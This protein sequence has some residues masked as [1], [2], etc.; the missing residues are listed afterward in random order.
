MW[1]LF[2]LTQYC[3]RTV[4]FQLCLA[5]FLAAFRR[6]SFFFLHFH[7]CFPCFFQAREPLFISESA[8]KCK[9]PSDLLSVFERFA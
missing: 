7:L 5:R 3:E 2:T 9:R 6:R 4:G 1:P 8:S